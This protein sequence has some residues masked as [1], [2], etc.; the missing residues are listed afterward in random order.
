MRILRASE[1]R[2][3]EAAAVAAGSSYAELMERAG[4]GAAAQILTLPA[5]NHSVLLLCGKGNNA[6]DAFV[7]GRLL[8]ERHW[9]VQYLLLCG[10]ALSPLAAEMLGRLAPL[11]EQVEAGGAG[12]GA[13]VLVDGVFGTG[14]R[15]VLPPEVAAAFRRANAAAGLRVALDLPSGL[16]SDTG[17][18]DS[19]TFAAHYTLTFGAYKPGLVM[20]RNRP[21][22]GDIRCI[23]IGL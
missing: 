14:F 1:M 17:A 3:A 6:G 4:A 16:A 22:T 11:A 5:R 18:A 21:L 10:R 15:G 2:Q 12:F 23:D 7:A 20:E 9:R 13:D 8:A 19:D